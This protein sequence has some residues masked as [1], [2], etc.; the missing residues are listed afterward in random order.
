V[1]GTEDGEIKLWDVASGQELRLLQPNKLGMYYMSID[2]L[3]FSPDGD[4][5]ISCSD[6]RTIKLWDATSGRLL[7][8]FDDQPGTMIQKSRTL[9]VGFSPDGKRVFSGTTSPDDKI[10]IWEVETGKLLSDLK[11]THVENWIGTYT[12]LIFTPSMDSFVAS[13]NFG[14]HLYDVTTAKPIREVEGLNENWMKVTVSADGRKAMMVDSNTLSIA[15]LETG[16][17]LHRIYPTKNDGFSSGAVFSPDG[18][19]FATGGY[20]G[21]LTTWDTATGQQR[22]RNFDD[23]GPITT[24]VYSPDG[25]FIITG[26]ANRTPETSPLDPQPPRQPFIQVWNATTGE[27]VRTFES[28]PSGK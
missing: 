16:K 14:S 19:T 13:S 12:A 21:S 8:T 3:S 6:D 10:R 17:Q 18:K 9:A 20:Q 1:T 15:E 2:H 24:L 25:Q 26:S 28:R 7:R 27:V 5:I 4:R 23:I 22:I 11:L